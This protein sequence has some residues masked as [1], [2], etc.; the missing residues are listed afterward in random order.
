MF[1]KLNLSHTITNMLVRRG[2]IDSYICFVLGIITI[3]IIYYCYYYL[4][5][6]IRGKCR[7]YKDPKK[8]KSDIFGKKASALAK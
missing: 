4:R 8:K 3:I 6:M 7:F 1:N 2:R 5:P